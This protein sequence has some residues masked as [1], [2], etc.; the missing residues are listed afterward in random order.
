MSEEVRIIQEGIT[1]T[2]ATYMVLRRLTKPFEEWDAYKLGIIDEKGK[3][4]RHPV[5]SEERDSWTS[6][7]KFVANLK[8][9]MQQFVGKSQL[10]AYLTSIYLLRDSIEV[11]GK[12]R[13]LLHE[14][15]DTL[16]S[17]KQC[18][19]YN[20]F[21]EMTKYD[22]SLDKSRDLEYNVYKFINKTSII[23]DDLNIQMV[24]EL[25]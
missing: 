5:S 1:S 10:A 13:L 19:I 22:M 20:V 16:S 17:Q 3:K 7:D 23:L 2:I 9:I 8:R 11:F 4:L 6:I 14:S 15:L 12:N 18:K 21:K 24:E 25:I